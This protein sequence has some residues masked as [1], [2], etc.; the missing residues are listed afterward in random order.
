MSKFCTKLSNIAHCVGEGGGYFR[1]EAGR[2]NVAEIKKL[3]LRP[4]SNFW[5]SFFRDSL[6]MQVIIVK[7]ARLQCILF[8]SQ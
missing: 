7:L 6:K 5:Q 4:S 2:H 8:S 1:G 3:L